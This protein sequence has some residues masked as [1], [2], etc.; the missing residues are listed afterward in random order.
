VVSLIAKAPRC[1]NSRIVDSEVSLSF[2]GTPLTGT[3]GERSRCVIPRSLWLGV[4]TL[5]LLGD[6]YVSVGILPGAK[7][8]WV[9]N[10]GFPCVAGEDMGGTFGC[11][12]REFRSYQPTS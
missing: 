7:K 4:L 9:L 3:Y 11:A 8:S 2:P 10:A 1:S 6:A 5:S 12:C